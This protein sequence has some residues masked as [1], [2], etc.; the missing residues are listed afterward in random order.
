[1]VNSAGATAPTTPPRSLH[2]E[3]V[4]KSRPLAVGFAAVG[5]HI[6]SLT[7]SDHGSLG[8][9]TTTKNPMQPE[10]CS[11]SFVA[12]RLFEECPSR[13]KSK[14]LQDSLE[15]VLDKILGGSH[16]VKGAL[17]AFVQYQLH[18]SHSLASIFCVRRPANAAPFELSDAPGPTVNAKLYIVLV[19][20]KAAKGVA[21]DGGCNGKGKGLGNGSNGTDEQKTE[22][23]FYVNQVPT[24]PDRNFKWINVL[25]TVEFKSKGGTL[26]PPALHYQVTE[27][28]LPKPGF[29]YLNLRKATK[30]S[31]EP[32]ASAVRSSNKPLNEPTNNK[33]G[34]DDVPSNKRL[35][36]ANRSKTADEN[37]IGEDCTDEKEPKNIRSQQRQSEAEI[38]AKVYDIAGKELKAGH[39]PNMVWFHKFE[40]TFTA[41]I[42]R[43]LGIQDPD[44]EGRSCVLIIIVLGKLILITSLSENELLHAWWKVVVLARQST[45]FYCHSSVQPFRYNPLIISI[46]DCDP[47]SRANQTYPRMDKIVVSL[48]ETT[49]RPSVLQELGRLRVLTGLA[50]IDI[51]MRP[52]RRFQN[53]AVLELR[54]VTFLSGSS[55]TNYAHAGN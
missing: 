8:M 47:L 36:I 5:E 9:P 29:K 51:M 41:K 14:L 37:Y 13:E 55:I 18:R 45:V 7:M 40:E 16:G 15:A 43:A 20:W 6:R 32:M 46:L 33:R 52:S 4:L 44:A 53:H 38:L 39:V 30:K 22:A 19:S 26:A 10:C 42:K 27:C 11:S 1:M 31:A 28:T 25:S 34:S 2:S 54:A 48:R 21:K 17:D 12:S 49:Q 23:N 50:V 35:E 24:E 3:S